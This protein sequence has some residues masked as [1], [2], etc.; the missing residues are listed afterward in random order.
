MDP[1]KKQEDQLSLDYE[2]VNIHNRLKPF[3]K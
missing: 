2:I 3:K 1:N